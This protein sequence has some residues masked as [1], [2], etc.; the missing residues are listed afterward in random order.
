MCGVD[1]VGVI[2]AC[3]RQSSD[4]PRLKPSSGPARLPRASMPWKAP[5]WPTPHLPPTPLG[6]RRS[7]VALARPAAEIWLRVRSAQVISDPTVLRPGPGSSSPAR[8]H[9]VVQRRETDLPETRHNPGVVSELL[10]PEGWVYASSPPVEAGD[11]GRFH[12]LFGRD[13]LIF[14]LQVLTVRPQV[15]PS[16][17][18]ALAERFDVEPGQRS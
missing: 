8:M 6:S 17:L 12:A 11:P 7:R 9:N 15:A 1:H 2:Q 18:R 14:A 4:A 3:S 13:S 5:W 10:S 16:T